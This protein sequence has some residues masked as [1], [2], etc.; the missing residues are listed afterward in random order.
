MITSACIDAPETQNFE[1]HLYHKFSLFWWESGQDWLT[2]Q[3][4]ETGGNCKQAEYDLEVIKLEK[5]SDCLPASCCKGTGNTPKSF[6][7]QTCI[8]E[9]ASTGVLSS[10]SLTSLGNRSEMPCNQGAENLPVRPHSLINNELSKV[11][12]LRNSDFVGL[13]YSGGSN[14]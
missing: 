10:L 8:E 14:H 11:I 5:K 13:R 7:Q 3:L 1:T 6:V 9:V 4:L 2:S 12:Q